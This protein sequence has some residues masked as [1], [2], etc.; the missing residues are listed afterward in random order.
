[1]VTIEVGSAYLDKRT[2]MSVVLGWAAKSPR[3]STKRL[4]SRVSLIEINSP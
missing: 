3:A 4:F 1:M 2:I